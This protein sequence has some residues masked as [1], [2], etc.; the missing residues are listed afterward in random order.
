MDKNDKQK[1]DSLFQMLADTAYTP[2]HHLKQDAKSPTI[3]HSRELVE[4]SVKIRQMAS[5]AKTLDAARMKKW[6]RRNGMLLP[7]LLFN[8]SWLMS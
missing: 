6:S 3:K 7:L 1:I 5:E 2:W 8:L 4:Q